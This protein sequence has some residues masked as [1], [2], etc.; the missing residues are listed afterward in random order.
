PGSTR[1]VIP[2]LGVDVVVLQGTTAASLRAGVGH[3]P[4]TPMP[5][6]VGDVAIAGHR[7]TYGR[8]FSNI[9]LLGPG[10]LV[11]L[12][13]PAGSCA[14]RVD[15]APFVV[16]PDDWAVV[17]NTPDRPTLTL[18]ACAPKGSAAR[19]IVV[20]AVMVTSEPPG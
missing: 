7:T 3:Y 4:G 12:E 2:K 5:C 8:P 16:A 13:T 20:K 10:D 15:R 1:I 11:V 14:Y 6:S 17:A 18:T 9:N 19:R